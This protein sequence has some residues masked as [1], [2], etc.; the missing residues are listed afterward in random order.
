MR[1]TKIKLL[2]LSLAGLFAIIS[3]VFFYA[4]R[5]QYNTKNPSIPGSLVKNSATTRG[6]DI[7]D[8]AGRNDTV[9]YLFETKSFETKIIDSEGNTF[10]YDI[11][12]DGSLVIHQP[13]VPGQAGNKGFASIEK[14]EK[15]AGKVVEKI[16]NNQIPPVI[17]ME[18]LKKMDVL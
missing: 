18:E 12:I 3:G 11:F 10:G 6:I 13:N 15:V 1:K 16:K 8:A 14:A 17:T 2:V 4:K 5:T 7:Q 9:P